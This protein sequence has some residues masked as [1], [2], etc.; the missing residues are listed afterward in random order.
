MTCLKVGHLL[1]V[2]G[3]SQMVAAAAMVAWRRC[4]NRPPRHHVCT[5]AAADNSCSV[6]HPP[7]SSYCCS[8]AIQQ[9]PTLLFPLLFMHA[10]QGPGG[11]RNHVVKFYRNGV[12][13]VDN[14]PPRHMDDPGNLDFIS[15]VS[16]GECPAELDPGT[17]DEPVTVNLLRAEE[18]YEMPKCGGACVHM[19]P[20][21]MPRKHLVYTVHIFIVSSA[22]VV[23]WAHILL[24]GACKDAVPLRMCP[25]CCAGMWPLQALAVHWAAAAAAVQAAAVQPRP[26]CQQMQPRLANGR[27]SMS[28]SRRRLFSCASTT[29]AAWSLA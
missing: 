26:R 14:G 8:Y 3:R 1:A 10:Q 27:A 22:V 16:R 5:V 21:Q 15:A 9:S 7:C 18:D 6:G 19:L 25:A 17:S 2:A 28:R 20:A 12:F 29:A 24:V 4:G 23:C 11:P 13:T